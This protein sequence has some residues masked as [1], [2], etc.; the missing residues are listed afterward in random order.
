MNLGPFVLVSLSMLFGL[1]PG[2]TGNTFIA[3]ATSAIVGDTIKVKLALWHG[4]TPMLI[5][6]IVTVLMGLSVYILQNQIRRLV[7]TLD[8]GPFI[9]P[10]R[11]YQLSW[12]AIEWVTHF[13]TRVLQNGSLPYYILT[14]VGTTTFLVGFTL[15]RYWDWQGVL[16]ADEIPKLYEIVIAGSII[17]AV[18]SIVRA[19]SR[20]AAVASLGVIGISI[21]LIYVL[22]GAPDLAMTQLSIETLTVILFVL[23]LYR[24]PR[25]SEFTGR[26]TRF[27]DALV[28]IAAGVMMTL[29]VLVITSTPLV[30]RLT[31]YFAENSYTLA[32]GRNIVNVILVD[33]RGIDTLGE[34]TV[35]AVAAI[36]VFALM[37]LRSKE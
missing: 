15:L 3:P 16:L 35:L 26:V 27:R 14:I 25:F 19:K 9:G 31:P 20:L 8:L 1:V 13:Q 17:I 32:K 11:L 18:I 22:F 23:V 12:Q 10:Q 7:Q 5:L 21:A 24:L 2:W 34:I 36:G 33:F 6:S 30:S 37:K 28:A 29:L 4:I